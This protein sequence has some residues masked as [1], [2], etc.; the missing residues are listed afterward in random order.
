MLIVLAVRVFDVN[1]NGRHARAT[2]TRG[3]LY[4][5]KIGDRV[6]VSRSPQPL[7]DAGRVLI[8]E[9]CDPQ[10]RIVMRHE[11]CSLRKIRV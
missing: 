9:G 10:A 2:N 1:D 11:V 6:I 3:M 5:A 4:Y 8:N 7:L